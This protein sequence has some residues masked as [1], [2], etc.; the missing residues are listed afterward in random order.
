MLIFVG[1]IFCE[2]PASE[3]FRNYILLD[4]LCLK[5]REPV[6]YH[7]SNHTA[8][9]EVLQV[10]PSD[11]SR[12]CH[13]EETLLTPSQVVDTSTINLRRYAVGALMAITCTNKSGRFQ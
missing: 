11:L 8:I 12:Y 2:G 1:S 6:G 3:D 4:I 5:L 10:S 13:F 9:R 7:C